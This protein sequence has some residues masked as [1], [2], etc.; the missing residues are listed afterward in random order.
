LRAG[1]A[2]ALAAVAPRG[3]GAERRLPPPSAVLTYQLSASAKGFK[4]NADSTLE[5]RLGGSEYRIVNRGSFLFFSFEWESTG[6][7]GEAGLA[8]SRYREMRNKR[9][10]ITEFDSASGRL[11]LPS[12]NEEALQPGTQDRL[13]VLLQ[14]AAIG[15]AEGGAFANGKAVSF[16]VAGSSR[17]DNWH[18]RAASRDQLS[19]P[20]GDVEAVHL[21]RER[22]HDDGQKIEVWLAPAHDWLP[23]RV[24]SN[25]ADGDFLDQVVRRIERP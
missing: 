1:A 17:S 18:F 3:I 13:S 2:F 6:N 20:M 21:I 24:L 11:K 5:W 7:I 9:V 23:V 22:D 14:L 4:I 19:T 25:E 15:R 12:G 8:P 10:K 16:R